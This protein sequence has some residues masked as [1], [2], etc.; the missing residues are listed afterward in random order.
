MFFIDF[1]LNL[2]LNNI[3]I[4]WFFRVYSYLEFRKRIKS[5]HRFTKHIIT[6]IS[7]QVLF[8]HIKR[9][10]NTLIPGKDNN[11]LKNFGLYE[12]EKSVLNE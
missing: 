8:I 6:Y 7:Q 3:Y 9:K 5:I 12:D 2:N 1:I 10:Q 4:I 11:I